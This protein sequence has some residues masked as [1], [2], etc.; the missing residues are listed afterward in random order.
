MIFDKDYDTSLWYI[1]NSDRKNGKA[2][3]KLLR[4]LPREFIFKIRE[5]LA[6]AKSDEIEDDISF[7]VYDS[8]YG[9]VFYNFNFDPFDTCIT[10]TKGIVAGEMEEDLFELMLCPITKDEIE[11]LEYSDEEWLGTV[12]NIVST[13]YIC[14][15]MQITKEIE[16]EYNIHHFPIGYYVSHNHEILNG[17]RE[18]VLYKRVN[19]NKVPYDLT[20]GNI[21]QRRLHM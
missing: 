14:D 6:K 10:I 19:I 20:R 17:R 2:L 15:K 21:Y 16:R 3:V 8:V 18:M 12:T 4:E 9:D 1:V 13:E 5:T 7:R 11:S